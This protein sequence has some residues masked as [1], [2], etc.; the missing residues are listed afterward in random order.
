MKKIRINRQRLEIYDSIDELPIN[1]F[2]LFNKYVLIDAGIGTD[3]NDV[4]GHILKI[5]SY[6]DSDVKLARKELNNMKDSLYLIMEGV[7]LKH[8]SFV[9]LIKSIN[10]K[11]LTDM[12]DENVKRISKELNVTKNWVSNMI[13][14]VKKNWTQN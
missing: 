10:G 8:L 1:R 4:I 13:D 9:P 2:H 5:N 12:S 7:N 11:P 14:A 3:L 6:L